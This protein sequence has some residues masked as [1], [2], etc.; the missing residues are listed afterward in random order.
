MAT[1]PDPLSDAS[2]SRGTL[3]G[4]CVLVVEDEY[5]IAR[6]VA[7][8]VRSLGAK[9]LGPVGRLAEAQDLCRNGTFD[10]AILDVQLADG[11]VYPLADELMARGVPIILATGFESAVL[12]PR[13]RDLPRLDKPYDDDEVL[14]RVLEVFG[15]KA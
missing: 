7:R 1:S 8:L 3:E 11:G 10:G 2:A 5:L 4:R 9:V 13:F 12:P 6:N 15:P 14:R